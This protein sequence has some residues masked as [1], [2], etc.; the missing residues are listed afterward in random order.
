MRKCSERL[1]RSNDGAVAPTVALSLLALIAA[2]GLAFDYA[3]MASL[4]SELQNAAD[5]AALAAATQLDRQPGSMEKAIA[6]AQSLV[7]NKTLMSNDGNADDRAI[8]VPTAGVIFYATKA[9]AENGTNGFT[10][11]TNYANANFVRVSVNPRRAHYALTPVVAAFR[12]ADLGA[13]A[14]SGVG[15]AICKVP[16]L[17][18]CNPQ[19]NVDPLNPLAFNANAYRGIGLHLV[20]GGGGSWTPGNFGYL[21]TGLGPGANVLEYALGANVPPGNCLAT[22]GV[23]TKP[24][25]NTSV[26]DAIN[27][28]FDIYENGLTNACT[29]GTCS[30]SPNVRKDVVRPAGSTNFGFKTGNDPWDLPLVRYLPDTSGVQ[31]TPYPTAMG[32]PRDKCH[33]T[34]QDGNCAGG[35]FGTGN[36]D[37]DLYFFVNHMPL[38]TA[39]AGGTAPTTPSNAWQTLNSLQTWALANGYT[40]A[41]IPNITRYDVYKWELA[42]DLLA[43]TLHSYPSHSTTQG[44]KTTDF[45]NYGRPQSGAGLPASATQLDRRV[46]SVAVI[47]CVQQNVQGQAKDVTVA[48]WVE[49]FLVEPSIARDRTVAGDIYVEVIRETTAGGIAPTNPQVVRRDV[50]YLIK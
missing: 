17:M 22:D 46:T 14:V 7:L 28:R 49:V 4:D 44:S 38:L 29:N 31:S 24:G 48:K 25:E 20:E 10:A 33:A 23:T 37:R 13:E 15:S 12:S 26:T 21:Q 47:N 41:T 39:Q 11:V 5:Q 32:H 27:T 1:I 9:D 30:P 3:R 42:A 40:V 35:R 16:P 34:S 18:M 45:N 36:W 2:G 19:E 6:A 50:P 43:D 8:T